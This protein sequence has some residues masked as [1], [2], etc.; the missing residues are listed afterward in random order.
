MIVVYWPPS[1]CQYYFYIS[2]KEKINL[3]QTSPEHVT[4]V[5]LASAYFPTHLSTVFISSPSLP[6][7]IACGVLAES[8][9]PNRCRIA[10][11]QSKLFRLP[12]DQKEEAH[13]ILYGII[14]HFYYPP[15]I[16]FCQSSRR[17][18]NVLK[19][20]FG[21]IQFLVLSPEMY[22]NIHSALRRRKPQ[23]AEAETERHTASLY[24]TMG[25]M[26]N[27]ICMRAL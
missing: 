1:C 17:A 26:G 9:Y 11:L 14:L 15:H 27:F 7:A 10:L 21:L 12:K 16:N 4:R 6:P 8:Q 23:K 22:A 20:N 13:T 18:R 25:R 19:N 24:G 3:F 2:I 5:F